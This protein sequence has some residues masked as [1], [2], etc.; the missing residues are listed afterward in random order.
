[1][2]FEYE[3]QPEGTR[4]PVAELYEFAGGPD[5]CLAVNTISGK[6]V[7]FY[8]DGDIDIQSTSW[9]ANPIKKFYPGDKITIT[10]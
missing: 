2:K 1:M 8:P 6:K 3:S 10:F 4:E 9:E 7:W 5:P